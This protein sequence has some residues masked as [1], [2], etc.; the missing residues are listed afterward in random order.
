MRRIDLMWNGEVISDA[1][2]ALK[3]SIPFWEN[4]YQSQLTDEEKRG[5]A[6]FCWWDTKAQRILPEPAKDYYR[7]MDEEKARSRFPDLQVTSDLEN[8]AILEDKLGAVNDALTAL[9][10]EL[11]M[12]SNKRR[13]LLLEAEKNDMTTRE[14]ADT[15]HVTLPRVR[16]LIIEAK[17][18]MGIPVPPQ[19]GGKSGCSN[20]EN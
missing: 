12:L 20:E 15:L 4:K 1:E 11:N 6:T 9:M 17:R 10:I 5:Y 19:K 7:K 3:F 18:K 16:Q 8:I 14:L 13:E 2:V